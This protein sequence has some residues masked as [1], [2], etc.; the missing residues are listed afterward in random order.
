MFMLPTYLLFLHLL[1][2]FCFEVTKT[3]QGS[4]NVLHTPYLSLTT[5]NHSK[6]LLLSHFEHISIDFR[7]E[8]KGIEIET[9]M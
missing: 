2:T 3:Y 6:E 9:S 4:S 7:S 5:I 8:D 1:L